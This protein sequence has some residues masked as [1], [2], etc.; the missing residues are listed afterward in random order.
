MSYWFL[1]LHSLSKQPP[2]PPSYY[3]Q[4]P[5]NY[6]NPFSR[7]HLHTPCMSKA[8]WRQALNICYL[9]PSLLVFTPPSLVHTALPCHVSYNSQQQNGGPASALLPVLQSIFHKWSGRFSYHQNHIMLLQAL[10]PSNRNQRRINPNSFTRPANFW[11]LHF[12]SALSCNLLFTHY[13]PGIQ[14]LSIH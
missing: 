5:K 10:K 7:S 6:A 14:V 11:T 9:H 4:K 2:H 1:F 13:A 3:T 8:Y 12:S